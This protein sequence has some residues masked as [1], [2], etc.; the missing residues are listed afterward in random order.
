M[1]RQVKILIIDD[2]RLIRQL[3]SRTISEMGSNHQF[4][5]L[6]AVSGS[7]GIVMAIANPPDLILLDVMM[8][9]IDGYEVCAR[10]RKETAT[11][12]VPIIMLTA[13]DQI[14]SKILGL[15]VGADD[16]MTKP[17]DMRELRA[18]ILA[19]LRRQGTETQQSFPLRVF[20]CHSSTDKATVRELHQRLSD[21][22]FVPWLDEKNL[23]PGQEWEQEIRNEVRKT[24]VVLVCLSRNAVQK[25]GFIQKEIRYALDVA[26][27]Q[28]PETIFIIP[29]RLEE[30]EVP[31]R[32]RRWQWVDIFEPNGYG[33]LLSAL[34]KRAELSA[35]QP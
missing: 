8:P 25:S 21:D 13:L 12:K 15:R 14:D 1:S 23:L 19:H 16:Y 9:G 5:V 3:I 33:R 10:L 29:A 18:R 7:E 4:K 20:L 27:E 32:L 2:D 22:G 6:E 24:D 31:E 26:D 11:A 35:T 28:P 34:K 17:F 30:C